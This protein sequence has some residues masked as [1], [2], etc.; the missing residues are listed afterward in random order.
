M[1]D[2]T[3]ASPRRAGRVSTDWRTWLTSPTK[4]SAGLTRRRYQQA[5]ILARHADPHRIVA[6]LLVDPRDEVPIDLADQHHADDLQRLGVVTRRPSRNSGSLPT[7]FIHVVHLRPAAM[8]QH[9]AHADAAQQQHV[10]RD[11]PLDRSSIALPPSFT[12][13]DLPAKCGCREAPRP[14][15]AR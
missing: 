3:G 4:P 13:T 8:D 14:G 7:R 15:R 1:V 11:R 10:L 2:T 5:A 12:T 6:R 9:A